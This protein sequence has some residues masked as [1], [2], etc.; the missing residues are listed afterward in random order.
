MSIFSKLISAV[1]GRDKASLAITPDEAVKPAYAIPTVRFDPERV[2]EAIKDDLKKNIRNTK[3]FDDAH[4]DRIYDAALRAISRGGDLATLFN[5]ITELDLPNVTKRRASEISRSLNS[6]A[7][8]LMNRDRQLS[9]GIKYAIWMYSG[10]PC[11][12]N[13]KNP[14]A[15]DIRQDAAHRAADGKKYGVGKGMLLN[16]KWT[17]PGREIGCKCASGSIIPGLD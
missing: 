14:S 12:A 11:Q 13:P 3:E 10:A 9:V 2:T 1:R 6:K 5:A 17:L 8:A 16:G 4:F 7:A 15:K